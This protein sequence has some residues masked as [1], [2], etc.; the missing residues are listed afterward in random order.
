MFLVKINS[1][2]KFFVVC[3]LFGFNGDVL[4]DYCKIYMFDVLVNDNMGSY[5]EL[6]IIE[7]GSKVVIVEMLIG[8]IG[9]VVCY[10]VCFLGLFIVMGDIDILVLLVVF[11]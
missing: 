10:D 1:L 6:V 4:V 9:F 3:M 8:N 11:I 5:C 7:V 2:E